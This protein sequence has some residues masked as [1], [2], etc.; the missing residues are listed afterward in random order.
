MGNKILKDHS[1]GGFISATIGSMIVYFFTRWQTPLEAGLIS[2]L[3]SVFSY[4]AFVRVMKSVNHQEHWDGME[5]F[6]GFFASG[7]A[8][9]GNIILCFILGFPAGENIFKVM[10]Q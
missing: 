4:F 10:A 7:I 6:T 8:Q 3:F 5:I 1:I 9:W 2:Y